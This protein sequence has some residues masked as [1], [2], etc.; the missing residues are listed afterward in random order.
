MRDSVSRQYTSEWLQH[1]RP[2]P[3]YDISINKLYDNIFKENPI[4]NDNLIV[5]FKT[6]FRRFLEN[7]SLSKFTG[8]DAFPHTDIC[9]GCTQFIDDIYQRIGTNNVM[10]FE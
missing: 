10:I 8:I 7:H 1:D 9:V 6:E 3:M 4:Y 5:D 2:Q